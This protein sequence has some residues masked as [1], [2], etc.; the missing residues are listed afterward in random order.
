MANKIPKFNETV[1]VFEDTTP[2]ESTTL[3]S[4]TSTA[5][6][7]DKPRISAAE[8]LLQGA[9]QGVTAGFADEI[10]GFVSAAKDKLTTDERAGFWEVYKKHQDVFEQRIAATREQHPW[11]MTGAEI[12]G[13]LAGPGKFAKG[14][15]AI[16]GLSA[17]EGLGRTEA[18]LTTGD[19]AEY[20]KAATDVVLYGATA[21]ALL[22][23][24]P[25]VIKGVTGGVGLIKNAVKKEST[26]SSLQLVDKI[27]DRMLKN[28]DAIDNMS[29]IMNDKNIQEAAL[30]F[31]TT[32][33]TKLNLAEFNALV[34]PEIQENL[35]KVAK[36]QAADSEL[37]T[38]V[39]SR[40]SKDKVA[41]K[42][43]RTELQ[44]FG[45]FLGRPSTPRSLEEAL[46]LSRET[47]LTGAKEA[48]RQGKFNDESYRLFVAQRYKL[49][50]LAADQ[51]SQYT[52]ATNGFKD[53]A[54]NAVRRLFTDPRYLAHEVD[55]QTGQITGI[56]LDDV[57]TSVNKHSSFVDKYYRVG[58][59]L[60][61]VLTQSK[62]S[63]TEM[64]LLITDKAYRTSKW[65]SL[66]PYQRNAV[67]SFKA[68]FDNFR[69]DL[70]N[71]GALIGKLEDYVPQ[72][73]LEIHDYIV[74]VDKW[75]KKGDIAQFLAK[76]DDV[77]LDA[78]RKETKNLDQFMSSVE[79]LFDNEPILTVKNLKDALSRMPA[80]TKM[81][82]SFDIEVS[83][84]FHR[85]G[86]IP[87]EVQELDIMRLWY[88]YVTNS[89]RGVHLG[90][91]LQA[92]EAELP[93]LRELGLPKYAEYLETYMKDING[94][95]RGIGKASQE[96]GQLYRNKVS[97]VFKDSTGIAAL[98][99]E[100]SMAAP[101]I[102][103][104]IAQS[105]YPNMLGVNPRATLRNYT[106]PFL[107]T[108]TDVAASS[109]YKYGM[110]CATA[111]FA[112]AMKMQAAAGKDYFKVA[113]ELL[114]KNNL[115]GAIQR[116][117]GVD[118]NMSR[119]FRSG[120]ARKLHKY[121][122][123]QEDLAMYMYKHSDSQNR[124]VTYFMA[125]KVVGDLA[126]GA[127][128]RKAGVALS[129]A[130]QN[131]LAFTRNI[132]SAYKTEITRALSSGKIDSV[133]QLMA[134][135]MVYKTQLVYGKA[136]MHEF[137][138]MAGPLFSMFT[139]WPVTVSSEMYSKWKTD[140]SAGMHQM[141]TKYLYP[142]IALASMNA[143]LS[144]EDTPRGKELTAGQGLSYYAPGYSIM[145]ISA[146]TTPPI[147]QTMT[148]IGKEVL[149]Y[150]QD[151][152]NKDPA[153]LERVLKKAA[154]TYIPGAVWYNAG[155]RVNPLV[156]NEANK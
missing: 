99:K 146:A 118:A 123:W 75:S 68:N 155:Q 112:K 16:V 69:V 71:E 95:P 98:G 62:I 150:M 79:R 114:E 116:F 84:A 57:A 82:N 131:A 70:R 111:G 29:A 42:A 93:V 53:P 113:G 8:A 36:T 50:E 72:K 27:T 87:R 78:F 24:A 47:A 37:L 1:P 92:L 59:Q 109:G 122:T 86:E 20:K 134:Q 17:L 119:G 128:A 142:M 102:F 101:E 141:G 44:D 73:A 103:T 90:R 31:S 15:K 23:G 58:A 96:L 149:S 9:A 89:S 85:R 115:A 14:A 107:M 132:E 22:Y 63:N 140:S 81:K 124:L 125:D 66:T 25:K 56:L 135:Y 148:D 127:A 45:T 151:P 54:H 117:E 4:F 100:A 33:T 32:Q 19:P 60:E 74:A 120:I 76:A 153:R 83:A 2:I 121:L 52:R 136:G 13:F 26:E 126:A 18:D 156:F 5:P 10:L 34:T 138:R 28:A 129:A 91:S 108:G 106:Q 145:T 51:A 61:K 133:R 41:Y 30:K 38:Q 105:I 65:S 77:P 55:R 97:M 40:L 88:G 7:E 110:E 137:G 143:L 39:Y 80:V 35:L 144:P 67:N 104:R 3:P 130:Q 46:S 154:R 152:A 48:I 11:L 43:F 64:T 49:E 94:V 147:A 139:K 12:V 21:G 6:I